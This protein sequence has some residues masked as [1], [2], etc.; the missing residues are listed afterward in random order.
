MKSYKIGIIGL[1]SIGTRHVK[2]IVAVLKEQ[3]KSYS[4][5][6][7]RSG[8]GKEPDSEVAKHVNQIYYSYDT[9]PNDYDV[10]FITNPTNLHFETIQQ[11]VSKTKHMFIEKPIFDNIDVTL[12]ELGLKRDSTYYVACP[13]RYTDVIQ[14]LKEQL[15]EMNVFSVRAICSSY[16]PEWR[17]NQD[18]RNSY[19]A[20]K[21]QGGGVS[22]DLIHEWDYLCYL[23]GEPDEVLNL[24]GTFSNLEIDSDDISLYIAKYDSMLVEVHLDYFGRQ[25]IREVQIFTDEDTIVGDLTNS[26]IRCL[27]SGEIISFKEQRN[28]YQYKEISNFFNIIEGRVPNDNDISKALR[29]LQIAK[30]G[31]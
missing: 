28:D 7:V 4:I 31:K 30:E 27:K 16:L 9:V 20:H 29:I 2:N 18:Y 15:R 25:T 6:L 13:L 21:D 26:E 11:Y 3:G 14:Y 10:L 1:G 5:D 8:R 22:I 17:P 19:S 23:F 24:R 12:K